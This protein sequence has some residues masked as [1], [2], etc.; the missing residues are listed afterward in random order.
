M[1]LKNRNAITE[2]LSVRMMLA[3]S[4]ETPRRAGRAICAS[5]APIRVP[6]SCIGGYRILAAPPALAAVATA[7]R[8]PCGARGKETPGSPRHS[9]VHAPPDRGSAGAR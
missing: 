7:M 5:N 2:T 3:I 1:N 4:V 6:D 9:D 8:D